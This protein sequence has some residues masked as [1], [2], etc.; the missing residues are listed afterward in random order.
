MNKIFFL[1]IAFFVLLGSVF[2]FSSEQVG[3]LNDLYWRTGFCLTG[4]EYV[5]WVN[6]EGVF[7]D[8]VQTW[9]GGVVIKSVVPVGKNRGALVH[10]HPWGLCYASDDDVRA[11]GLLV[12]AKGFFVQCGW[13][14]FKEF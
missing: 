4:L 7:L 5:A 11:K 9:F 13:G 6:D 3:A 8:G 12:K 14:V 10:S 1:L 2:A